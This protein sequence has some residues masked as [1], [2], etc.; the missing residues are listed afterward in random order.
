[1]W[2]F[3]AYLGVGITDIYPPLCTSLY[4]SESG[5]VC[6]CWNTIIDKPHTELHLSCL[7]PEA[8]VHDMNAYYT[9]SAKFV[10]FIIIIIDF[11]GYTCK[12][13]QLIFHMI[14]PTPTVLICNCLYILCSSI[15]QVSEFHNVLHLVLR[16]IPVAMLQ[17]K[18]STDPDGIPEICLPPGG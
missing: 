14:S 15:L 7:E 17:I 18:E 11:I 12:S 2:L 16:D 8:R 3:K 5:L 9:H 6:D 4:C 10:S 13:L 1:M